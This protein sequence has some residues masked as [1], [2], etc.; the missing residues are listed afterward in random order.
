MWNVQYSIFSINIYL[1]CR[2]ILLKGIELNMD[3]YER[4]SRPLY[5]L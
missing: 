3:G 4:L 2:F 1:P 5:E